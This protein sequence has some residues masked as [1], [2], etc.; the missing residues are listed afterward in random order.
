[1]CVSVVAI[2]DRR[3]TGRR[4]IFEAIGDKLDRGSRIGDEHKIELLRIRIEE[5]QCALAN[6]IHSMAGNC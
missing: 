5:T 3:V 1:M 2:P 6:S 4:M